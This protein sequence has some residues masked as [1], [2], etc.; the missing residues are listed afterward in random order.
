[1]ITGWKL[2]K[3]EREDFSQ[4]RL[5]EQ[6]QE[7]KHKFQSLTGEWTSVEAMGDKVGKDV[8]VQFDGLVYYTKMF[9]LCP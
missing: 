5:N 9:D 3:R 2:S 8:W 6:D 7:Q 1:M 4:L